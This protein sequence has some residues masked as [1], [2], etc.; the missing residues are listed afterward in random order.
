[1][2]VCVLVMV[3]RLK[4]WM[5]DGV[6]CLKKISSYFYYKVITLS[7]LSL[8]LTF[9]CVSCDDDVLFLLSFVAS[10]NA[11]PPPSSSSPSLS[12]PQPQ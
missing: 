8:F 3:N 10:S 6:S 9:S 1:M 11:V 2:C 4:K 12:V 7:S 5:T